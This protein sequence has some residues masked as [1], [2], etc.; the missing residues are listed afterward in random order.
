MKICCLHCVY[1]YR[2]I[3]RVSQT[4]SQTTSGI[5]AGGYRTVRAEGRRCWKGEICSN[6]QAT[7]QIP[8]SVIKEAKVICGLLDMDGKRR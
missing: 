6:G 4:A 3:V 5:P 2:Q 1:G 8:H 7:V